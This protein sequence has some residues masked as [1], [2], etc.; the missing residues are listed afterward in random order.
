MCRSTA[1]VHGIQTGPD[2]SDDAFLGMLTGEGNQDDP[3]AI[4]VSLEGNLVTLHID[5]G[6]EVTVI[7]EQT[8]KTIGRPEMS[9]PDKTLR[10][11][12]SHAIST[13]G[14][15]TGT[16]TLETRQTEGDIYVVRGL[17]KSL[18]GGPAIADLE[19]IKRIATVNLSPKEQFL[20]LFQGLGKLEGDHMVELRED[21][22][23]SH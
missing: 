7:T 1:K 20:S 21:A 13:L 16:L 18:L 14:K 2:S 12:D 8:W 3:W 11:P 9:P 5:T 15:F 19:L 10:G 17:S 4:T 22:S 6:A 23:H